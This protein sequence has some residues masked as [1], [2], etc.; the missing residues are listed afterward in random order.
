[1]AG[2]GREWPLFEFSSCLASSSAAARRA[3]RA[4]AGIAAEGWRTRRARYTALFYGPHSPR[5]WLYESASLGGS[6]LGRECFA[7][8]RLYR[9]AGLE[10]AGAELPDHA[11]VEL[12]F[13]SHLAERQVTEVERAGEWR[14]LERAFIRKHAGR[15]L[16]ELGRNLVGSG[17]EVY[18]PLG[19]L[20]AGWLQERA[21][22]PHRLRA[23]ST[24][25]YRLALPDAGNCTLCGFCV[26][27]CPARVLFVQESETETCLM[28]SI[29]GCN[30][31]RQCERICPPQVIQ[32]LEQFR[33]N[34]GGSRPG[35][36]TV[37][38][39]LKR[40][41]RASCPTCGKPTVS[42]AELDFVAS[43]IGADQWQEYCRECRSQWM[44]S[45]P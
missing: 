18:A 35:G 16:P 36:A 43:R 25:R 11:S 41:A 7:L 40:S 5:I 2:A 39:V 12:S 1:M 37:R 44:E 21:R 10:T 26:Q 38:N 15:W 14:Q 13:L 27:V 28:A 34:G 17:D 29:A 8:D 19:E 45:K 33:R 30:G 22:D 20:L 9:A 31:C 24:R 23:S 4:L 6:L 3:T 32:V 42:R